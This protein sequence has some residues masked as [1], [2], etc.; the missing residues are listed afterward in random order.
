MSLTVAVRRDTSSFPSATILSFTSVAV[1]RSALAG[2]VCIA[3]FVLVESQ[4]LL[5]LMPFVIGLA[6][7]LAVPTML[8]LSG[9]RYAG[10]A[11]ALF[12]LL[13]TLLQVG[14]IALPGALGVVSDWAGLRAGLSLLVVSCVLVALLV[15]LSHRSD[16]VESSSTSEETA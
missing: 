9:D 6:I 11:G 10:H 12:G 3:M 1:I 2:A 15:H 13:L 5:V 7:A 4:A 16:Q 14:G 8:A